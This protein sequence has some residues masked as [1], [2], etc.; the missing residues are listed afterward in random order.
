LNTFYFNNKNN[1]VKS[2]FLPEEKICLTNHSLYWKNSIFYT[3]LTSVIHNSEA[4]W[5]NEALA[6]I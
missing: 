2:T 3:P 6:N 4:M 1:D 5:K